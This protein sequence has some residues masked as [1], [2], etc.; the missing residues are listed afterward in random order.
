M[1]A[2][3]AYRS[4]QEQL[5]DAADADGQIAEA[6]LACASKLSGIPAKTIHAVVR[7]WIEEEPLDL[8]RRARR[9]GIV[10][11]LET[12]RRRGLKLGV[13]SD[14]PALRKL[15]AMELLDFFD[16][17]VTAQDPEVQRFKPHPRGLEVTLR[18][19]GVRGEH[20]LYVGDR[21]DVDEVVAAR[22]GLASLLLDCSV[23]GSL[24]TARYTSCIELA[25]VMGGGSVT[26]A[27]APTA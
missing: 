23:A 11:L 27:Q 14:Y 5:R 22:A 9:H 2:L 26:R 3:Q 25:R 4:A 7:R 6:Q 16:V 8:L 17:V 13:F 10:D 15:E 20:A 19:L 24:H 18:R 1:R 12:A 21:R